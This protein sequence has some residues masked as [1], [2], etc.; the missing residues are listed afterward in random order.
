MSKKI[1]SLGLFMIG[2]RLLA[3]SFLNLLRFLKIFQLYARYFCFFSLFTS[4]ILEY[5]H[6]IWLR[7]RFLFYVAHA[8]KVTKQH[9]SG[10]ICRAFLEDTEVHSLSLTQ[11]TFLLKHNKD[12][13]FSHHVYD[14]LALE[15]KDSPLCKPHSKWLNQMKKYLTK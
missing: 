10:I 7:K 2:W 5:D 1:C 14:L 6:S 11:S 8:N 15:V 3:N 13:N 4:Y 9:I 12:E